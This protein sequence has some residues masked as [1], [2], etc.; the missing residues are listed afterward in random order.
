M[1]SLKCSL[2]GTTGDLIGEGECELREGNRASVVMPKPKLAPVP[3]EGPLTLILVDGRQLPVMLL[4]TRTL[5]PDGSGTEREAYELQVVVPEGQQE[6]K[7]RRGLVG[8]VRSL[9]GRG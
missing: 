5:P 9:F 2:Y 4:E 8:A 1:A 7:G 3:G 6:Q